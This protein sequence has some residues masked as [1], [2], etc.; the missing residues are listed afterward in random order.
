MAY[1]FNY[2]ILCTKQVKSVSKA[3]KHLPL[4]QK[5]QL[6]FLWGLFNSKD[7]NYI[8]EEISDEMSQKINIIK[9]KLFTLDKRLKA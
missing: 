1:I 2:S 5:L 9:R 4:Y 6:C 3:K 7:L 8:S